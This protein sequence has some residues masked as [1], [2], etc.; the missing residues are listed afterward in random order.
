MTPYDE[1]RADAAPAMAHWSLLAEW[2][3]TPPEGFKA[4]PFSASV[5]MLDQRSFF[6]AS[7]WG[8]LYR[9]DDS[10]R[11]WAEITDDKF[12]GGVKAI[13]AV[14]RINALVAASQHLVDDRF[15]GVQGV[16]VT[17]DV[18]ANWTSLFRSVPGIGSATGYRAGTPHI[19]AVTPSGGLVIGMNAGI[20]D[21]PFS[22]YS[23]YGMFFG[24]PKP[25][26]GRTWNVDKWRGGWNEMFPPTNTVSEPSASQVTTALAFGGEHMFGATSASR[27]GADR[28]YGHEWQ[29]QAVGVEL[30]G[31]T[32][33]AATAD[34]AILYAATADNVLWHSEDAGKQWVA[35]DDRIA[36]L[37][38]HGELIRT[39]NLGADGQLDSVCLIG[40]QSAAFLAWSTED[41]QS[42]LYGMIGAERQARA[43]LAEARRGLKTQLLSAETALADATEMSGSAD[44]FRHATE[45]LR[46]RS[47]GPEG[48]HR[49]REDER[50]RAREERAGDCRQYRRPGAERGR[51]TAARRR[52]GGADSGAGRTEADPGGRARTGGRHAGCQRRPGRRANP[53]REFRGHA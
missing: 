52:C 1:S 11:T 20:K 47:D 30:G 6:V 23:S 24:D 46:H 16:F 43:D 31:I 27:G 21:A 17:Q 33:M 29:L 8:A 28:F 45:T 39:I 13:L 41:L 37:A 32:A 3:G 40:P 25:D 26:W 51:R 15:Q 4:A 38:G 9:S 22:L 12:K 14:P 35:F 5:A 53:C 34:G 2:N 18:G 19:L 44:R 7:P 10:G 50:A 36:A 42:A 49:G 48:Q